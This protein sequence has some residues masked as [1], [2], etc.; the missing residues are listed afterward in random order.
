MKQINADFFSDQFLK[1]WDY[2]KEKQNMNSMV[3][4]KNET[5]KEEFDLINE[6]YNRLYSS[7]IEKIEILN[8]LD[9]FKNLLATSNEFLANQ[10]V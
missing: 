10:I 8:H 3:S 9:K 5:I 6:L 2:L 4:L 7:N 1:F